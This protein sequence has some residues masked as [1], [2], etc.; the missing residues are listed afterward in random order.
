MHYVCFQFCLELYSPQGK[1]IKACKT[2]T[3]GKVV[4]GKH[5]SY[6]IS[7]ATA[8]ERDEWIKSI[9]SEP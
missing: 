6:R 1:M 3:D 7:A 4:M 5:N 2:E 8:E 9:R